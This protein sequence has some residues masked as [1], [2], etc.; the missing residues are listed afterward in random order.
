MNVCFGGEP[1]HYPCAQFPA[2]KLFALAFLISVTSSVFIF[3]CIVLVFVF[4]LK[5]ACVTHLLVQCVDN[6]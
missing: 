3:V 1:D 2:S 4:V 6:C 5:V